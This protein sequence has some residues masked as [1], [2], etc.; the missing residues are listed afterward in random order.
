[1][2]VP[3]ASVAEE[4]SVA[5]GEL[6]QGLGRSCARHGTPKGCKNPSTGGLLASL[7]VHRARTGLL[8]T[9]NRAAKPSEFIWGNNSELA[10][11]SWVSLCQHRVIVRHVPPSL[12]D[13][14]GCF[15]STPRGV[16][17]APTTQPRGWVSSWEIPAGQKQ[18]GFVGRCCFRQKFV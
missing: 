8:G 2:T 1:M 6:G 13:T 18:R 9:V 17:V 11:G 16:R 5:V 10:R 3:G 14:M 4:P 15:C 7:C 12:S